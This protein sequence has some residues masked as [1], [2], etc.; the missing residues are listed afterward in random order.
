VSVYALVRT[1]APHV[2][3]QNPREK[4]AHKKNK[5]TL[6][7]QNKISAHLDLLAVAERLVGQGERLFC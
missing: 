7:I 5:K 3:Q 6:T 1:E 4:N 2:D